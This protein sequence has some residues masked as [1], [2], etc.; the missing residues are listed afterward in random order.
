MLV[1]MKNLDK[2]I[3]L[4]KDEECVY[5]QTHN[6]PDHDSVA[7]AFGLQ[8]LLK[9]RG[10]TSCLIYEG[11]IQRDSLKQ[12]I[13]HLHIPIEPAR[14][15]PLTSKDKIIIVDGCKGNKNVT[16]LIGDEV[17]VI[18]HH[19]VISP[20]DV[21]FSDIRPRYG[22]CSTIM[23][24]YFKEEDVEIPPSIGTALF[25]GLLMDTSLM[26]RGVC[27]EDLSA[28]SNLYPVADNNFVN[29]NLR[30]DIQTKDLDF[31]EKAIQ[32]KRIQDSFAFCYLEDGCNQNLLG[33]LGDFFMAVREVDFV[34]LCAHNKEQINFSV[35]SEVARWNSA[36]IIQEILRGIGFGGGHADMAGGIIKDVS[37]FN[38]DEIFEKL[39]RELAKTKA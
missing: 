32:N 25:A 18:D 33:I 31:F 22:A 39:R 26:T 28:Y 9:K 17:A 20:D 30:N 8:Y 6:F 27:E 3:P 35:R 14:K 7:S 11:A 15:H 12:V 21:R 16:D 4:I 5:I 23:Y 37:K 36:L 19:E 24:E 2:L 29:F 10:I 13:D 38:P 34:F 1:T